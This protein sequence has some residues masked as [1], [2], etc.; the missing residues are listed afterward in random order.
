V[1]KKKGW[2]NVIRFATVAD[3]KQPVSASRPPWILAD[4]GYRS[5]VPALNLEICA[6]VCRVHYFDRL[7]AAQRQVALRVNRKTPIVVSKRTLVLSQTQR[8]CERAA[9]ER[10]T[11]PFHHHRDSRECLPNSPGQQHCGI[12]IGL[13]EES[14][15]L[16]SSA[17][18]RR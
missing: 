8:P 13:I 3:A 1:P 4:F 15:D 9:T 7:Q 18:S 14:L 11:L 10:G 5:T 17:P 2:S 16:A 6:C 12:G